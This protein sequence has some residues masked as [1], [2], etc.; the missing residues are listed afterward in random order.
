MLNLPEKKKVVFQS[1]PKCTGAASQDYLKY[2][3]GPNSCMPEFLFDF[4]TFLFCRVIN[5]SYTQGKEAQSD[6]CPQTMCYKLA[7]STPPKS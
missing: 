4:G 3:D 2:L 1:S 6:L 5:P 7:Q